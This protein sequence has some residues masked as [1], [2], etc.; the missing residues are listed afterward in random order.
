M[1]ICP[2]GVS[3]VV[4][5]E[6]QIVHRDRCHECRDENSAPASD[7]KAVARLRR[8]WA[9]VAPL[10]SQPVPRADLRDD[11]RVEHLREGQEA[12]VPWRADVPL[13]DERATTGED[14]LLAALNLPE[15][16]AEAA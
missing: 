12:D 15:L 1:T 7:I 10:R 4:Y 6:N 8:T 5:R 16:A 13:Y 14:A 9:S 11:D 3:F 2:C